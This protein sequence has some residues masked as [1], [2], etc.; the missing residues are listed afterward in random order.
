MM[1]G[2]GFLGVLFISTW[3]LQA[4]AGVS[5]GYSTYPTDPEIG[6]LPPLCKVKLRSDQ[7]SPEYQSMLDAYGPDFIHTHHYCTGLNFINR[8]YSARSAQEK[9]F[10]LKSAIDNFG[11]M[12]TH[13]KP[14][15]SLMYDVYLNR[16][17]VFSLLKRDAEAIADL[18][19]AVELNPKASKSYVTLAD[20][21][22]K[23]KQDNKALEI[24]TEGLRQV[25][26]SKALKRRYDELGG[27]KPYPEPYP[28]PEA[29]TETADAAAKTPDPALTPAAIRAKR[30]GDA[31]ASDKSDEA[32]AATQSAATPAATTPPRNPWCRFCA[33]DG[34]QPNVPS[35]PSTPA[36]PPT[37]AP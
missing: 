3:S 14:D 7:K 26:N 35:P 18:Q 19:K 25:P 8:Y 22:T 16:G 12:I 23:L 30:D 37:T 32:S 4:M 9:D 29:K 6:V 31:P 20:I 34:A 36:A 33:E 11:Y 10:D 27:K 21:Y 17:V 2:Y 28:A 24:T 1:R 5:A 13:A 15:F